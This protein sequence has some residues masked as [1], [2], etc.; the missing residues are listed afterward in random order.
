MEVPFIEKRKFRLFS[1]I[2]DMLETN[3][4]IFADF[5]TPLA[6]G[7]DL[8]GHEMKNFL[9]PL[10]RKNGGSGSGEMLIKAHFMQFKPISKDYYE[11]E[12]IFL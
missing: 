3:G 12:V 11:V 2:M 7:N 5:F 6:D 4:T 9:Q 8:V 10:V 1:Y